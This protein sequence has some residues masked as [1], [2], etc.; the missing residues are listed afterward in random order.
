MPEIAISIPF[1]FRHV[2]HVGRTA[3]E[4]F[5]LDVDFAE[6]EPDWMEVVQRAGVSQKQ[7]ND[8]ELL[9]F[10]IDFTLKNSDPKEVIGDLVQEM[11]QKKVGSFLEVIILSL[12]LLLFFSPTTL[13][14]LDS[15][16]IVFF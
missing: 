2:A 5:G 16:F 1:G 6:L 4:G 15:S 8:G 14:M 13:E 9:Q 3:S 12:L 7:L 11:K 10:V